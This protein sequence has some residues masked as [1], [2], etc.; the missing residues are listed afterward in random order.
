M[1]TCP[2]SK[3]LQKLSSVY[4][5]LN[6]PRWRLAMKTV[7]SS[8]ITPQ[9]RWSLLKWTVADLFYSKT[10]IMRT[11]E[12]LHSYRLNRKW[13]MSRQPGH[14]LRWRR[15]LT[16]LRKDRIADQALLD[17]KVDEFTRDSFM[18][19]RTSL[20]SRQAPKSLAM[21]RQQMISLA[22]TGLLS[23]VTKGSF[24]CQIT[25]TLKYRWVV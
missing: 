7:K 22:T 25:S 10:H 24:Q 1:I 14:S 4:Y 17:H 9:R 12:H 21:L 3:P 5:S 23:T 13:E 18:W 11:R 20:R 19:R 6:R 16:R 8:L 2:A 15:I